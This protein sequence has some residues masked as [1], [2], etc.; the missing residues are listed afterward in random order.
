MWGRL[1]IDSL[2]GILIM[3][4]SGQSVC[5][6]TH[7]LCPARQPASGCTM[8]Q[9]QM[10]D[11]TGQT[12]AFVA[13]HRPPLAALAGA[14]LVWAFIQLSIEMVEGDVQGFDLAIVR[15]ALSLRLGHAW[16]TD[17]MR[18]LSGL[19]STSVLTLCTVAAAGYLAVAG[20]RRKALLV[21]V[22][23]ITG[24]G[25]MSLLKELFARPRPNSGF[26]ELVAP[27]MGFPSGHAT[28]SAI[29][30]LTVA[31]LLAASRT[32]AIERTTILA[33]AGMLTFLVGLSRIVLG[34]HWATDGAAG[35][36]FGAAWALAWLLFERRLSKTRAD[37]TC[38]HR[39]DNP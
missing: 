21:L 8:Q 32:R 17:V 37:N 24:V 18:D 11:R 22:A 39:P 2:I 34:V 13:A 3:A 27:G 38:G 12:L 25:A 31:A 5:S 9:P 16:I 30:F 14:L 6:P 26:A 28:M 33:I 15:A 23:V 36:A 4:V 1:R 20:A 7:S 10:N 35:W 19:G 29:V